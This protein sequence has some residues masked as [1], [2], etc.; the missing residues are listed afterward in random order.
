MTTFGFNTSIPV[1]TRTGERPV[2][3]G[4]PH[5][6][7][8]ARRALNVS[9]AALGL[10]LAAPIMAVVALAVKL[11]SKGPVLYRQ[12]RIGLD[13]R[14]SNGGNH[15]RKMDLGGK[16]FTIYKFRT[17]QVAEPGKDEQVW[18]HS[19][20]ARVTRVGSFLRRTRLDELPQLFNVLIGDMNIVG[21][22]PEQ[23]AIFQN[24][25]GE[26]AGYAA[27]QRVRPGI[28][29]QAQITL[30]YDTCVDDVRKKVAADLDYIA[31]Q[32][33]V[34]DLRIMALT[35]PVVILRKGGW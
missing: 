20:D 15:R 30:H 34:E 27:R 7:E 10:V 33:L 5:E 18:A 6:K 31:K 17:M 2:Q 13:L 9:V 1:Y 11:T 21:P 35:A 16:P 32:S 28:T 8:G 25:R 12:Q 4:H 22:R 23:P 26:V 24:L 19:N 14:E 29:G 3:V